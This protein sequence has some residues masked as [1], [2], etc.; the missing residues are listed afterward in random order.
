M[1]ESQKRYRLS[2][3]L[4]EEE[5]TGKHPLERVEDY[6]LNRD[7]PVERSDDNELWSEVPSQWGALRLMVIYHEDNACI[8][9]SC[10]L[11][12]K[13]PKHLHTKIFELLSLINEQVWL[14]HFEIWQEEWMPVYR[15]V[16]PLRGTYL[17]SKQIEFI[18]KA[19]IYE[20]ERFFPAFQWVIWSD[21][22]P[23]EAMAVVMIETV[24]EA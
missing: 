8:Q 6:L 22:S 14:G 18:V 15:V 19:I 12:M 2:T 3:L 16:V 4:V 5:M 9:F 10:Y 1:A 7:W 24:G 20:S 13:A 17:S 23:T 11:N 21:R